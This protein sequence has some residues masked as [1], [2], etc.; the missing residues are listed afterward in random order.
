MD[1]RPP[2]LFNRSLGPWRWREGIASVS[3][4]QAVGRLWPSVS[5]LRSCREN[6]LFTFI[7]AFINRDRFASFFGCAIMVVVRKEHK[8]RHFSTI[9]CADHSDQGC[10]AFVACHVYLSFRQDL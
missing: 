6:P 5:F 1:S 3:Q 10:A 2:H 8:A 9:E 7:A 4:R